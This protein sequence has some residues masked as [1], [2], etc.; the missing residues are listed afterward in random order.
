VLNILLFLL[1]SLA[2]AQPS[3]PA[4]AVNELLNADRSFSEAGP[5][6]PFIDIAEK[7][8]ADDVIVPLPNGRFAESRAAAIEAMR[9]NN[10]NVTGRAEWTPIRGGISADGRHGFTFGYM[11]LRRP[12]RSVVP[13]KYLAYW[14][15]KPEGWRVAAYKRRV[16]PAG[17]VPMELMSA[18]LPAKLTH[19]ATASAEA[20]DS[21]KRAEQAFSDSAQK[22]GLGPAFTQFGRPDAMNL[23]GPNDAAFVI[24]NEAVGRS[25]G[26][27]NEGQGSPVSW[28]ADRVL[29][30]SSGDLGVT[31]GLIRPNDPAKRDNANAF[32]T[33][34]RRDDPSQPW[35]YIAE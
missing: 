3:T 32:F 23:G 20:A 35:R 14:V 31:F 30:A 1:T 29:V 11:T 13:M 21:L 33:I 9:A 10:D 34:W 15:R 17:E 24:G 18:S 6:A 16:R 25:V 28:N 2:Q 26:A 5:K 22:I 19:P 12:N 8:F 7:M 27:G 4:D